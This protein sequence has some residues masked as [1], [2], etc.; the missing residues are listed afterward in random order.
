MPVRSAGFTAVQQ[1]TL[2]FIMRGPDGLNTLTVSLISCPAAPFLFS[3]V[4]PTWLRSLWQVSTLEAPSVSPSL[5][6]HCR[7]CMCPAFENMRLR[8]LKNMNIQDIRRNMPSNLHLL[9]LRQGKNGRHYPS[10][11][12]EST[13]P[14]LCYVGTSI[15]SGT[16]CDCFV[17]TRNSCLTMDLLKKNDDHQSV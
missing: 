11:L 16:G 1:F 13:P 3:L 2:R 4:F 5:A 17:G 8:L 15:E 7:R 6:S 12:G 10:E 9:S 14:F